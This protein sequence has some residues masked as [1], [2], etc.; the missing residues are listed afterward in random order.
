[1]LGAAR[2]EG[3]GN[4]RSG[5]EDVDDDNEYFSSDQENQANSRNVWNRKTRSSLS[6]DFGRRDDYDASLLVNY[7]SDNVDPSTD[8]TVPEIDARL[9]RL[10]ELE[11]KTLK[12]SALVSGIQSRKTISPLSAFARTIVKLGESYVEEDGLSV[13]A[14]TLDVGPIDAG[15]HSVHEASEESMN[16]ESGREDEESDSVSM[17]RHG[18]ERSGE[19][20]SGSEEGSAYEGEES[21]SHAA[22]DVRR[23]QRF[24]VEEVRPP[25]DTFT[26][27]ERRTVEAAYLDSGVHDEFDPR[28]IGVHN[29]RVEWPMEHQYGEHE[30]GVVSANRLA[31]PSS[32]SSSRS[33]ARFAEE[34]PSPSNRGSLSS[35]RSDQMRDGGFEASIHS[36]MQ[37]RLS[38]SSSSMKS[39]AKRTLVDDTSE[40]EGC[41]FDAQR[42]VAET[43]NDSSLH[44]AQSRAQPS[45]NSA[46]SK[47]DETTQ[48]EASEGFLQMIREA[49]DSLSVINSAA[50]KIWLKQQQKLKVRI[51]QELQREQDAAQQEQAVKDK[52]LESVM[53]SLRVQNDEGGDTREREQ[54]SGHVQPAESTFH[55][56]RLE[57]IM[58]EVEDEWMSEKQERDSNVNVHHQTQV[59]SPFQEADLKRPDSSASTFWNDMLVSSSHLKRNNPSL[60][61]SPSMSRTAIDTSELALQR[62]QQQQLEDEHSESYKHE[63]KRVHSPKT[64]ARLLL[65]EVEYHEAIHDAHVQLAMMEQAQVVEQAQGE[66]INVANAFK[67]EMESNMAS[68]QLAFEHAVLAQQFDGDLR[69]ITHELESIRHTQSNEIAA[70]AAAMQAELRKASLRESTVQTD[71][72]KRTDAAT[73]AKLYVESGTTT[74][75]VASDAAVQYEPPDEEGIAHSIT[76]MRHQSPA[77]HAVPAMGVSEAR[78]TEMASSAELGYSEEEYEEDHFERES[79]S[80]V[81]RRSVSEVASSEALD[82]IPEGESGHEMDDS[83][84]EIVSE[85]EKDGDDLTGEAKQSVASSTPYEDDEVSSE[86]VEDEDKSGRSRA[87]SIPSS[88]IGEADAV[89]DEND[90][91][92]TDDK[93]APIASTSMDYDD[94]FEAS[95]SHRQQQP[96]DQSGGGE[97]DIVDEDG[98][99]IGSSA[100]DE[101][102]EDDA[103]EDSDL[104][105]SDAVALVGSEYLSEFR[106]D[107]KDES[108]VAVGV[109][110]IPQQS[111]RVEPQVARYS[112]YMPV[113]TSRIAE[114]EKPFLNRYANYHSD[115]LAQAFQRD[116][117]MRKQSDDSLL[118]LR[119]QVLEQR[120]QRDLQSVD[121]A[122]AATNGAT[123]SHNLR[124]H[125]TSHELTLRKEALKMAFLSEKANVDSLKAASM[126]RYY[127]D[128]L[129]FQSLMSGTTPSVNVVMATQMHQFVPATPRLDAPTQWPSQLFHTPA[130]NQQSLQPEPT[131]RESRTSTGKDD[132]GDEF[133]SVSGEVEEHSNRDVSED[134]VQSQQSIGSEK[135]DQGD[136]SEIEIEE[137]AKAEVEGDGM[138]SEVSEKYEEDD[139]YDEDFASISHS[140]TR[141]AAQNSVAD[142]GVEDDDL[143]ERSIE[144]DNA[145]AAVSVVE[146]DHISDKSGETGVDDEEAGADDGDIKEDGGEYEDEFASISGSDG[147]SVELT[148]KQRYSNDFEAAGEDDESSKVHVAS[149]PLDADESMLVVEQSGSEDSSMTRLLIEQANTLHQETKEHSGVETKR[150]EEKMARKKI[151]A[152]ELIQAKERLIT[153]QKHIFKQ[154]EEKRQVDALAQIALQMDVTTEV[155]RA[156]V[157]IKQQ[158]E[159]DM[160]TLRQAFPAL[161]GTNSARPQEVAQVTETTSTQ[162]VQQRRKFS[163][164]NTVLPENHPA[165]EHPVESNVLER[166]IETEAAEEFVQ[167]DEYEVDSFEQEQSVPDD[168]DIEDDRSVAEEEYGSFEDDESRVDESNR[169]NGLESSTNG[170]IED[171][172]D[173]I[174]SDAG[175]EGTSAQ[176][177]AASEVQSE[178]DGIGD[179]IAFDVPTDGNELEG[180][181]EDDE[182]SGVG[183]EDAYEDD[184]F[185]DA[186]V[187]GE[188]EH[189]QMKP[190]QPGQR[191]EA[192]DQEG[193]DASDESEYSD[194]SF[195]NGSA[196]SSVVSSSH[197]PGEELPKTAARKYDDMA[198]EARKN[199]API[200]QGEQQQIH[201]SID[202]LSPALDAVASQLYPPEVDDVSVDTGVK[203]LLTAPQ[204]LLV[205]DD[206]Q[207]SPNVSVT[208]LSVSV[209]HEEE[210][211]SKSIEEQTKRLEELKRMILN[212]K[213]EILSVQKHMRIEKRKE[214]LRAEEKRLWDEM[215]RVEADLR[216]DEATL[217]LTRQRNRLESIRLEAKH[218]EHKVRTVGDLDLLEGFAYIER[219]EK[220]SVGTE[221]IVQDGATTKKTVWGA[222]SDMVCQTDGTIGGIDE[223]VDLLRGYAYVEDAEAIEQPS[224]TEST[225]RTASSEVCELESRL[226]SPTLEE[227]GNAANKGWSTSNSAAPAESS[228]ITMDNNEITGS[229][230]AQVDTAVDLLDGYPH[231]EDAEQ[232]VDSDEDLLAV[233]DYVED[234]ERLRPGDGSDLR[235]SV[236]PSVR[237]EG[238]LPAPDEIEGYSDEADAL[239][240]D[241]D[242]SESQLFVMDED[243]LADGQY[244]RS[245]DEA[246]ASDVES[247]HVPTEDPSLEA[248]VGLQHRRNKEE[249]GSE[250]ESDVQNVEEH[251][252]IGYDCPDEL[253]DCVAAT[254]YAEMFASMMEG[255]RE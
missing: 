253:V 201:V 221:R 234:A 105:D 31:S 78:S 150:I 217:E 172:G 29:I 175:G 97:D 236:R 151:K 90:Q 9:R 56:E 204:P 215:E 247:A 42:G 52:L 62:A 118:L 115:E 254:I 89:D 41:A 96:L 244:P 128:L 158:L 192:S 58:Q 104:K 27:I 37:Q 246:F 212:R 173:D 55:H 73:S 119:L 76:A 120:F 251:G 226:P 64:L 240:N 225:A 125:Q 232:V 157:D 238:S 82:E 63:A 106:E 154:E 117:E 142:A 23:E 200:E 174:A 83:G 16:R 140:E 67:E 156:K 178:N 223:S 141:N 121:E 70:A 20:R 222:T 59:N 47:A 102:D 72:L 7:S 162:Q 111:R 176:D 11:E 44:L 160:K 219:A 185:D 159:S 171:A 8:S 164:A 216:T 233:F 65:A 184:F 60:K 179:G 51:E 2:S 53:N 85:D 86:N 146:S 77:A 211:L 79:Q 50:K 14:P 57:D 165:S 5:S 230:Y 130:D 129:A 190:K 186:Q 116:L 143:E 18:I 100:A 131:E 124:A 255:T 24:G 166:E 235:D 33:D 182:E 197:L 198:T 66:T 183:Y 35:D 108:K 188:S 13:P 15:Q 155:N 147:T 19:G 110:S 187:E 250:G 249:A 136:V 10:L 54:S 12:L 169:E 205:A 103:R 206:S 163:P 6:S 107:T 209:S 220:P 48:I 122:I 32:S 112:A 231:I 101:I 38:P 181:I 75:P 210:V 152:V 94:D 135:D 170:G 191:E 126:A 243:E 114:A 74:S 242:G 137:S 195:E 248:Q 239:S 229:G 208:H 45:A 84:A 241:G 109:P 28:S 199:D 127:Q 21:E 22:I 202:D 196:S 61:V 4:R 133:E 189:E 25:A 113:T 228:A 46:L 71:E 99:F 252:D 203:D 92:Y 40:H 180:D 69:D 49:D 80:V 168:D 218:Q 26:D 148:G 43:V 39:S 93:Q 153:Q 36:Y 245:S 30:G 34:Q 161:L 91:S 145:S 87:E 237:E 95:S 224:T 214:Q 193:L 227:S 149:K 138:E 139:A 177:S 3:D 98:E 123:P 134:D 132:Y 144:S 167:E 1:M 194:E 17:D 68:H 81:D 88:E 213:D 207:M